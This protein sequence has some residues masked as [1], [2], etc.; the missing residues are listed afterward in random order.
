MAGRRTIAIT[1]ATRGIGRA[2]VLRWAAEGHVVHGC[3]RSEEALAELRAACPSSSSFRRVD[4]ADARDVEGW[5]SEVLGATGPPDLLIN[6]AGIINSRAP[7]WEVPED[8]MARVL[9]VNVLGTVH[10]IRAF[11]PAMIE[12]GRGVVVNLSSGWGQ[13]SAPMVGPY[14][15]SKFA[16]EGLTG[17]LAAELPED[18]VAV[19]LQPGII[20]TEMLDT[21]F[22]ADASAHWSPEEWVD[23]AAPFILGLGPEHRGKSVRVPGSVEP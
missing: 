22:G 13:F 3:G 4:V 17:S 10:V 2:L 23:V 11:V 16:V 15:A 7:L 18:V 14:C 12:R 20:H 19:A 1:G 21:A 8:E 9:G 5:A 6:N